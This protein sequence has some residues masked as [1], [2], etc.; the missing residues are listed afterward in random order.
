LGSLVK[1]I[2]RK[3]RKA[4][5]SPIGRA[6]TRRLKGIAKK[7]LPAVGGALG[8]IVAPGAGTAIGSA[9]GSAAGRMFGLELEGLSPEDQEF[10]VARRVVR[11]A[12]DAAKTATKAPPS[13]PAPQV[14]QA[15]VA[16]AA[17][18]HAP[19]LIAGSRR[20]MRRGRGGKWV[21]RGRTIILYGV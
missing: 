14:A 3:A 10:E 20:P 6:L 19:G 5:R 7:A 9:L 21:R 16:A 2:G 17:R 15:A 1:K 12:G 18:K 13:A 8:S 4:I 11:L